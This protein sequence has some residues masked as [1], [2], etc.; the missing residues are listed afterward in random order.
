MDKEKVKKGAPAWSA[1]ILAVATAITTTAQHLSAQTERDN[2]EL[3]RVASDKYVVEQLL[4][5]ID[6]LNDDMDRIND[7]IYDLT[8][9]VRVYDR[10][11]DMGV[12]TSIGEPPG[13]EFVDN[14]PDPTAT[15]MSKPEMPQP[16][17]KAK[18]RKQLRE[19]IFEELEQKAILP[20]KP[21]PLG[22][23][24]QAEE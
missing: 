7:D 13:N 2:D 1:V 3:V 23:Q 9:Q 24:Q 17:K 22:Q 15:V 16:K 12:I 21:K 19:T 11:V 8:I 20:P 10:L 18:A 6:G 5:Q 4:D 14:P